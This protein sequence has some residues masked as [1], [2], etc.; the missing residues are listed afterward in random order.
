MTWFAYVKGHDPREYSGVYD[1]TRLDTVWLDK[2]RQNRQHPG[3][4]RGSLP[5]SRSRL[6][7][8]CKSRSPA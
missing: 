7:T 6:V 8:D 3:S 1:V 2:W 5:A 4:S